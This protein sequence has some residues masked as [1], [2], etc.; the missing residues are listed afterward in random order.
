MVAPPPDSDP[1]E[2]QIHP[3]DSDPGEPQIHPPD[4]DPGSLAY[5]SLA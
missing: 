2:P 4:S 1:G 3:P 5:P